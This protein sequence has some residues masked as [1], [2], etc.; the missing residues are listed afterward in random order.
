MRELNADFLES[1]R[2]RNL[3]S[4]H[5]TPDQLPVKYDI[6]NGKPINDWDFPTR[7]FNMFS[8][9]NFNLVQS[10]GRTLLFNSN[11]DMRLSVMYS[12]TGVSLRDSSEVR[13]LYA[14]ALGKQN[15]IEL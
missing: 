4:E 6:L 2:N 8:P 11:Y 3:I 5:M 13:S 9:V 10:P 14:Q 1:I 12:P 15:L 7:V